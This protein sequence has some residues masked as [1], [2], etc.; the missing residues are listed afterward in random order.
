ME[1][2]A[3]VIG[4]GGIVGFVISIIFLI[5]AIVRWDSKV[6]PVIGIVVSV[7]LF[8][9]G[10]E[11]LPSNSVPASGQP[12]VTVTGTPLPEDEDT[13]EED[14]VWAVSFTPVNDFRYVL[15][16]SSHTITLTRYKGDDTKILLSPVYTVGGEDYALVSLGD[17]ACFFGET[18]ITSVCIPEGVTHMGDSTFNSCAALQYLY[19]PSTVEAVTSGFLSYLGNYTVYTDSQVMLPRERDTNDYEEQIDETSVS[20]ELGE[21]VGRA[22]NGLLAGFAAGLESSSQEPAPMEIYYGGTA[23]QW[24]SFQ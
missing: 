6:G 23:E 17:D 7:I 3:R 8:I 9:V 24:K 13:P 16:K 18:S 22:A 10:G 5:A 14:G 1:I 12:P 4:I 15:D 21:S 2:L 19:L 11:L 20:G